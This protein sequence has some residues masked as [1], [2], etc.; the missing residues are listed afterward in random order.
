MDAGMVSTLA[1]T[2]VAYIS[3]YLAHAGEESAKEL[4]KSLFHFV[5][6]K[7]KQD[8]QQ[9]AVSDL[10]NNPESISAKYGLA[11]KVAELIKEDPSTRD[12]LAHMMRDSQA[13]RISMTARDNAKMVGK[14]IGDV[15]FARKT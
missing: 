13:D 7:F 15:N 6:D 10:K 1:G 5:S 11:S 2:V 4:G 12:I 3:S 14:V 8:H 9:A